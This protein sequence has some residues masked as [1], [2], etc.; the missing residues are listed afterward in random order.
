M[1]CPEK[2][3]MSCSVKMPCLANHSGCELW[4]F[5]IFVCTLMCHPNRKHSY[6]FGMPNCASQSSIIFEV[7]SYKARYWPDKRWLS[8]AD[9]RFWQS[10]FIQGSCRTNLRVQS[11]IWFCWRDLFWTSS[12]D[13]RGSPFGESLDWS[14]PYSIHLIQDPYQKVGSASLRDRRLGRIIAVR[15]DVHEL[16]EY[17]SFD[18][19]LSSWD[20]QE[21]LPVTIDTFYLATN[22]FE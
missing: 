18:W 13:E 4:L 6:H 21:A 12:A 3:K 1:Q 8:Y 20:S 16:V 11:L 19:V 17:D 7:T 22:M 10:C 9:W 5:C 2:T 15:M 14:T